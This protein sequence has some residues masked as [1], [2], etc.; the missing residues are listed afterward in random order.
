VMVMVVLRKRDGET[1]VGDAGVEGMM[2][3]STRDREEMLHKPFVFDLSVNGAGWFEGIYAIVRYI[4]LPE[5]NCRYHPG[6]PAFQLR[7]RKLTHSNGHVIISF[8]IAF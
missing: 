4:F 5:G 7:N 1:L 8:D 2:S 6:A 3:S